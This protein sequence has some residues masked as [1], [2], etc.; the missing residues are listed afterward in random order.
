MVSKRPLAIIAACLAFASMTGSAIAQ[1][2]LSVPPSATVSSTPYRINPGDEL[3]VLV[4]V[5]RDF[6][7][8]Y[9]S[10]L[11]APLHSRWSVR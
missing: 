8:T 2:P 1:A 9:L 10:S 4:W 11:T 5:T 6:S 3:A 7:A